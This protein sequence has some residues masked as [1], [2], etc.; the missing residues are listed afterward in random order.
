M[1]LG[2]RDLLASGRVTVDVTDVLPLAQA[3]QAHRRL[4]S[5]ATQGKLVLDVR[6]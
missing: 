1:A 3:A 5:G 6:R 2:A 4:E